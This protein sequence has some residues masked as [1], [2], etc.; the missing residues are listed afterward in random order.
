MSRNQKAKL[1]K[2]IN[3]LD[4]KVDVMPLGMV[5]HSRVSAL[6]EAKA[7]DP[8]PGTKHPVLKRL[9]LNL[10]KNCKGHQKIKRRAGWGGA[11][12]EG[13]LSEGD[14]LR[15]KLAKCSLWALFD[16]LT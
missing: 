7:A 4:S 9:F 3:K 16:D 11:G 1:L 5:E 12:S 2:T 15:Y 10:N 14:F 13:L 6:R 8:W